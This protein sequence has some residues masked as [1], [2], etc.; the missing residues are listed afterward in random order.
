MK[1]VSLSKQLIWLF[2][3]VLLITTLG[4]SL[5]MSFTLNRSYQKMNYSH[6]EEYLQS[7]KTI[8]H[9]H[10]LKQDNQYNGEFQVIIGRIDK[11]EEEGYR[12]A[13]NCSSEVIARIVNQ[14]ILKEPPF[15]PRKGSFTFLDTTYFYVTDYVEEEFFVVFTTGGY[16]VS[17]REQSGFALMFVF[18]IIFFIGGLIIA[19]WSKQTVTRINNIRRHVASLPD[20]DYK[21]IYQDTGNDEISDLSHS[22]EGMRQKIQYHEQTKQ[23]ILQNVSHDLKTPLAVIKSYAEAIGDGVEHVDS[24]QVIIEQANLLQNKVEKLLQL[25]RLEYLEHDQEFQEVKVKGIIE[26]IVNN[27]KHLSDI[28]FE[29]NLSDISFVGYYENFFTVFDNIIDNAIRYA[30]TKIVIYSKNYS[31]IIYNDGDPVEE[32]FIQQ[33]FTPYE[34]GSKG[35]FGLGMSIAQKTL[36]FFHLS[37]EVRNEEVGVSFIISKRKKL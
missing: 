36:S 21:N 18:M 16:I 28:Q 35:Q 10:G 8:F 27:Y 9:E 31:V 14:A 5:V 19:S 4:F 13:S 32:Q 24:T 15:Q 11:I 26:T 7:T 3:I 37:L 29:V 1:K 12:Y 2:L 20:S 22:I 6:L 30:K 33:G 23:E 25:N 17:M 34:K